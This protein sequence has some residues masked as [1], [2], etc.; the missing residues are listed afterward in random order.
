MKLRRSIALIAVGALTL[1]AC[2]TSGATPSDVTFDVELIEIKGAT[3]G[4]PAPEPDPSTLS[5][6]YGYKAPGEY[7]ADNPDKWQVATYMFSP[8]AM[9]VVEGDEVTFRLFG[10]NGDHHA[11]T[12]VGPDGSTVVNSFDMSRGQE[13]MVTFTAD[14]LGHYKFIC[15]THAPTMTAD[16]LSVSG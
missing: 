1:V 3:D 16:L 13:T 6:G 5:S 11:M 12:V 8:A 10:I 4:I 15:S 2:G 14:Q 7:D 9:T